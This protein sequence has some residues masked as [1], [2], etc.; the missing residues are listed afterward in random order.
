MKKV[1]I[2]INL[3]KIICGWNLENN[4]YDVVNVLII[5]AS[6]AV[7]KARLIYSDTKQFI[8]IFN[9]FK[10]EIKR[11]DETFTNTKKKQNCSIIK[12]REWIDLK[13]HLNIINYQVS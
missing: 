2:D 7:Y 1:D 6:F 13:I 11:L 4:K 3:E 8:P 9:L 12:S 5:L 10:I